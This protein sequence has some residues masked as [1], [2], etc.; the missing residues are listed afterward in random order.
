[1]KI[2]LQFCPGMRA[3]KATILIPFQLFIPLHSFRHNIACIQHK[4][5]ESAGG[6]TTAFSIYCVCVL[7][8]LVK[9]SLRVKIW[10]QIEQVKGFSPVCILVWMVKCPL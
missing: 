3:R 10:P 6:H 2:A 9:S 4:C 8:W 7:V 1:M 5:M